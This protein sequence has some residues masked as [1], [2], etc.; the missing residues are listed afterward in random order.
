MS[1]VDILCASQRPNYVIYSTPSFI[2]YLG[3]ALAARLR[4]AKLILDVRDVW[5]DSLAELGSLKK[6]KLP[7]KILEKINK[8]CFENSDLIIS[9][10]P[11]LDKKLS[12]QGVKT[13]FCYLPSGINKN[14]RIVRKYN[15]QNDNRIGYFGG[16]NH[17]NAIEDLLSAFNSANQKINNIEL[18]I[19]PVTNQSIAN[20]ENL[21]APNIVLHNSLSKRQAMQE[22]TSFPVLVAA[23]NDLEIYDYGIGAN[24][25]AEYF[26]S[27]AAIVLAYSGDRAGLPSP[28]KA[29]HY[30]IANDPISVASALLL[31]L[32]HKDTAVSA[33]AEKLRKESLV[34]YE[35]SNIADRLKIMLESL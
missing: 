8:I 17:A 34:V 1:F 5:P 35:Y 3:A 9:N 13:N 22:M 11:R 18:H 25:L 21:I 26:T 15:K 4:G 12:K 16:L 28:N 7:Y 10:L 20:K 32:K 24:K 6:N 31:A 23:T 19:Y 27:G 30:A 33:D 2:G 29:M 14:E